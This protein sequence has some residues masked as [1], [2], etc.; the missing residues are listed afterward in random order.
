MKSRAIVFLVLTLLLV[1]ALATAQNQ[2]IPEKPDPLFF[3]KIATTVASN[4]RLSS[5]DG[6]LGIFVSE[7]HWADALKDSDLG[8][9]FKLKEV[10]AKPGRSAACVFSQ[11]KDAATCVYFDGTSPYGEASVKAGAQGGLQ[12]IDIAAAYK[13]VSSEMLKKT[14]HQWRFD[15]TD[16]NTDD[17]VALP[18]FGISESAA[19]RVP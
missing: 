6:N 10:E 14:D 7:Q 2:P 1:A 18:A 15:E 13:S 3:V 12:G 9:F 16:A 19:S 4:V 17:G 11:E 5:L 8:P